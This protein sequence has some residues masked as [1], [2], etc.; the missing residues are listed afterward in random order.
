MTT[1]T[2]R[3]HA[4]GV[5][6]PRGRRCH[7]MHRSPDWPYVT[8]CANAVVVTVLTPADGELDL[9]AVCAREAAARS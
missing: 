5:R 7:R 3:E 4:A 1:T 8:R 2:P 6:R 9:C